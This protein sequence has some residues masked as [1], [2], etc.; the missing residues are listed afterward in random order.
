M[1]SQCHRP[2]AGLGHREAFR[3]EQVA[4]APAVAALEEME[5]LG[6]GLEVREVAVGNRGRQEF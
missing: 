3:A 2:E 1:N 6:S 4:E 5:V